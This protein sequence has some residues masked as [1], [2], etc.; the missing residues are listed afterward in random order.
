MV[1]GFQ[2]QSTAKQ[3]GGIG[4]SRIVLN[5]FKTQSFNSL[6]NEQELNQKTSACREEPG[7]GRCDG[8]EAS[9]GKVRHSNPRGLTPD[10]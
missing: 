10:S 6:T 8:E 9:K 5:L 7:V 3:Q 4:F 1:S 2:H